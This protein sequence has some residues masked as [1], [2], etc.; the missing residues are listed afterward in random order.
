MVSPVTVIA[1]THDEKQYNNSMD[2]SFYKWIR[3]LVM[4]SRKKL[5]YIYV[6]LF[7]ILY[8]DVNDSERLV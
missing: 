2:I 8:H 4:L 7:F 5:C 1:A 3:L 6:L